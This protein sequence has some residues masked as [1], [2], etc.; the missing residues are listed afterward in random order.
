MA[1]TRESCI[2]TGRAAVRCLSCDLIGAK[3]RTR[4]EC[5]EH[6]EMNGPK[7]YMAGFTP[8]KKELACWHFKRTVWRLSMPY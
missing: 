1:P 5:C 6:R 2:S 8:V 3:E 7:N 4:R